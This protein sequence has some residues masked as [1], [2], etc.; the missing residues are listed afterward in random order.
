MDRL[1]SDIQKI[2][3][4]Q[5]GP[6]YVQNKLTELEDRSSQNNL[7]IDGIKE[8]ERDVEWLE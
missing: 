3:E 4:Y 2:Y 6:Y 7:R 8:T 5:I 1:D